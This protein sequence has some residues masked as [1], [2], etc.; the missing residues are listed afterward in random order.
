MD[1]GPSPLDPA[2]Y[3]SPWLLLALALVVLLVIAT[4][5]GMNRRR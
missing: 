5:I 4:V 3:E 1:E 2:T